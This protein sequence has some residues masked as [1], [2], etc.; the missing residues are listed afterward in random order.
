MSKNF[1]QLII[2][3]FDFNLS[4]DIF[5]KLAGLPKLVSLTILNSKLTSL[6]E[7]L[8]ESF[9]NLTNLTYLFISDTEMRSLPANFGNL[10]N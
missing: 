1:N 10:N 6:P 5:N 2:A 9:E 7:S 8:P 4:F 3:N